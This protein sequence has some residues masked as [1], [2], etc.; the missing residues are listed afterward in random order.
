MSSH[1]VTKQL[2]TSPE[3][4]QDAL[5]D[6]DSVTSHVQTM[7][8]S[9]AFGK[10]SIDLQ[11]PHVVVGCQQIRHISPNSFLKMHDHTNFEKNNV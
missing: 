7:S 5:V 10:I 1:D 8:V 2:L 9:D 3:A 6:G 4:S 11:Q